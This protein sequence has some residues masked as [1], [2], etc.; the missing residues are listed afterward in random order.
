ML[1]SLYISLS[2]IKQQQY[3]SACCR[4][5]KA[6]SVLDYSSILYSRILNLLYTAATLKITKD[7]RDPKELKSEKYLAHLW[8][9]PPS[10]TETWVGSLLV[11][12]P[13]W[14]RWEETIVS[15]A[16]Q[17]PNLGSDPQTDGKNIENMKYFDSCLWK[18]WQF[19]CA[20][21]GVELCW[22]KLRGRHLVKMIR[23][24]LQFVVY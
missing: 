18:T 2:A 5:D 21:H 19:S 7:S 15:E 20:G 16:H 22:Q 13:L 23:S 8:E 12:I 24:S 10:L 14:L 1:Y 17:T 9:S 6:T 4:K 11:S 3:S